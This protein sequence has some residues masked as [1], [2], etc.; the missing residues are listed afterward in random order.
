MQS[1]IAAL[2][3][4]DAW[5]D[6]KPATESHRAVPADRPLLQYGGRQGPLRGKARG[7]A[8]DAAEARAPVL[9]FRGREKFLSG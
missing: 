1:A 7:A 6:A 4:F 9:F 2:E 5:E 3:T 8:A